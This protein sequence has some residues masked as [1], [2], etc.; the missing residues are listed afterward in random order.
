VRIEKGFGK[1]I[2]SAT[3]K[4][5]ELR[6]RIIFPLYPQKLRWNKRDLK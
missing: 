5:F 6:R 3:P 2:S 1:D 4:R